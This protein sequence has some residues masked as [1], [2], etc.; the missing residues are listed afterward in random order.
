MKQ[1]KVGAKVKREKRI[2]KQKSRTRKFWK[3]RK[4][5]KEVVNQVD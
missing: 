3:D 1:R 5:E 2:T 4:K